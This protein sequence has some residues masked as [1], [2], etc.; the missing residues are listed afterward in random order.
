MIK[1]RVGIVI[2]LTGLFSLCFVQTANGAPQVDTSKI[3]SATSVSAETIEPAPTSS[4]SPSTAD[5]G[6]SQTAAPAAPAPAPPPAQKQAAATT[7]K[8]SVSTPQARSQAAAYPRFGMSQGFQPIE[9]P[10][11]ELASVLD[12]I[13]ATGAKVVRLDL[14]WAQIQAKGPA[15]FDF[16]NTLRVYNAAIARGF[17]VLPVTSSIPGWAGSVAPSSDTSYFNFMFQAGLVLIPRGIS[18][19]ELWNE[20]NLTGMTP[21]QYTAMALIPGSSGFRAAG[22]QLGKTVT[23]VSTGLAPAKT[24]GG[25]YSQLDFLRGIYAAGGSGYF[26][27]VGTHPYTWPADPAIAS[28]WNWMQ[29]TSELHDLMVRQ[30][31]GSKSIWATEFGFPTNLGDRGVSEETQAQFI[32]NGAAVWASFPWAGTLVFYSFRDL[33]GPDADPEHHFGLIRVDG[34]AKPA[35]AA[36][37]GIIAQG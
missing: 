32:A 22:A 10:D 18:T 25:N 16:A 7:A 35:L 23:I 37:T 3:D 17:T 13:A 6:A 28:S 5:P 31:D 29:K 33:A 36:V 26:D 8:S 21:Q 27:V 4:P 9:L 14:P 20:A 34:S 30:G 15:S 2:A 19:V 12:G 1:R 24:G 11:A